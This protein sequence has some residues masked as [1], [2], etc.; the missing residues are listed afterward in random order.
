MKVEIRLF[1]TLGDFSIRDTP[2]TM[3]KSLD[4]P[5]T[6]AKIIEEL[7]LP[8]N[9]P[10]IIIVNGLHAAPDYVLQ[11]GDIMSVFPPIAGG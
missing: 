2:S 9:I 11:D 8:E 5:T 10:K 1:G 6:T 7:D 4:A 3:I